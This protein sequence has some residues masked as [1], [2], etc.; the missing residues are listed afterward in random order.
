[1]KNI[2]QSS[3]RKSDRISNKKIKEERKRFAGHALCSCNFAGVFRYEIMLNSSH[4]ACQVIQLNP[5]NKKN[6]LKNV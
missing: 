6:Y 3:P 2:L 4:R 1:M 5:D